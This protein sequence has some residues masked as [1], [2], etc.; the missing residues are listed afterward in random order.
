LKSDYPFLIASLARY[1][2]APRHPDALVLAGASYAFTKGFR[3]HHG[4]ATAREAYVPVLLRNLSLNG[5][6]PVRTSDLLKIF[7][8]PRL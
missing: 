6:A 1:F 4:G 7:E 8:T 5:N 3:G 2:S